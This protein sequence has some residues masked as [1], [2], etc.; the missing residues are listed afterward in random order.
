MVKDGDQPVEYVTVDLTPLLKI[1]IT[2]RN[3]LPSHKE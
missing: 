3:F 2:G 1:P